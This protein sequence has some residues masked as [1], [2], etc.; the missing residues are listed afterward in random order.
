MPVY[1]LGSFV[2]IDKLVEIG[3]N[4]GITI[5]ED[6]TEALGSSKTENTQEPWFAF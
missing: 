2:D 5:L 4:Y 1:V 3:N 6:S